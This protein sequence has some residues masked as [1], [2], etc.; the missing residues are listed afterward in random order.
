MPV[1]MAAPAMPRMEDGD[2]EP[3]QHHVED[4]AQEGEDEA[5]VG[6][7]HGDI[8]HLEDNAEDG[9]G[10]GDQDG[11]HVRPAEGQQGVVGA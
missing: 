9:E 8:A 7:A 5:Q 11:D 2:E 1:A 3:I 6:L 4:A 10:D